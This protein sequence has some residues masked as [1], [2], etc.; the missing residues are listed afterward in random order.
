MQSDHAASRESKPLPPW[1]RY[2]GWIAVPGTL[3]CAFRSVYEHTL[4]TW[5][6]GVQTL[7]FSLAHTEPGLMLLMAV[8][9]AL[10]CI[11]LVGVIVATGL[12][13]LGRTG[14]PQ[15]NLFPMAILVMAF[16]LLMVPYE[17]WMALSV[18]L[19]KAPAYWPEYLE[20]GAGEGQKYL[21]KT[22]LD[23]GV[24]VDAKGS[25]GTALNAACVG[26]QI[27][28]AQYLLSKGADVNQAPSCQGQAAPPS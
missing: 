10:A 12:R 25:F 24:P 27:A 18:G 9:Q 5:R 28:M 2:I 19:G 11:F 1:L 14:W 21:V 13:L 3:A 15:V 6:H 17:F 23:K 8:S 4:L 7:G 16:L 22:V 20:Y 26:K